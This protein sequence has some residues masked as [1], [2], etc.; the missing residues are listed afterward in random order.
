MKI[1]LAKK[2][3]S[4]KLP[5]YKYLKQ[6]YR[7]AFPKAERLPWFFLMKRAQKQFI[8]FIAFYDD[9][10]FVGFAYNITRNDLTYIFYLAV[11]AKYRGQGFGS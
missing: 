10:N 4:P 5:E 6:L 8:E 9:D 11:D 2:I 3:V 7:K 1:I